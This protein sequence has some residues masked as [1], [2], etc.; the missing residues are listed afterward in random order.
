VSAPTGRLDPA[1]ALRASFAIYKD[2]VGV[3]FPAALGVYGVSFLAGIALAG[4]V[5]G[6]ILLSILSIVLSYIFTGAVV[7]LV[8]DVQDGRLDAS[9]GQ[10]ISS[11]TPALLPLLLASLLSG[12]IIGIGFVLLIVP[13]LIAMTFLLVVAPVVVI[14]R[15]GV[16]AALGRSRELVSGHGWQAFGVVAYVFVLNIVVGIIAGALGAPFGDTGSAVVQWIVSAAVFPVVAIVYTVA[17][18]RLRELK[19]EGPVSTDIGGSPLGGGP[20]PSQPAPPTTPAAPQQPSQ[21]L[22]GVPGSGSSEGPTGIPG[23]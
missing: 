4:S 3:L 18:L 5:A 14:E 23:A 8:R 22:P 1:E 20:V 19:G 2:N 6:A 7:Q 21:G 9:I 17:Y 11:V 15:P 13:G 10:L 12:V 16:I